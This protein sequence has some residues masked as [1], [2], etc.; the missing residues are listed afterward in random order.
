MGVYF[1]ASAARSCGRSGPTMT[2][3]SPH[4]SS[5]PPLEEEDDGVELLGPTS[6]VVHQVSRA[7]RPVAPT[8]P[9]A[10]GPSVVIAPQAELPALGGARQKRVIE[11]TLVIRDRQQVEDIRAGI[12]R[13]DRRRARKKVQGV[14]FWGTASA[15]AFGFGTAVAFFAASG[16]TH[17]AAVDARFP[18]AVSAERAAEPASVAARTSTERDADATGDEMGA[19]GAHQRRGDGTSPT[20]P[21][22]TAPRP[23]GEVISLADLPD[24][25][26][27][28]PA[29]GQ[30][31]RGGDEREATG[32][33]TRAPAVVSLEDL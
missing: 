25:V 17:E 15:L 26:D 11:P 22:T 8:D 14:L 23:A 5:W 2:T 19:R 18:G 20:P 1:R 24:A 32:T 29:G 7:P 9:G 6:Q 16:E 33:S 27:A 4:A 21:D 31:E 12:R 28:A 3:S 13:A 10:D 30:R